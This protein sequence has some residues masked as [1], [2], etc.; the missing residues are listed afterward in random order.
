MDGKKDTD[1][2][3]K[4]NTQKTHR[5]RLVLAQLAADQ[6]LD[7]VRRFKGP[8]PVQDGRHGWPRRRQQAGLVVVVVVVVASAPAAAA[9]LA[10]LARR[11]HGRHGRRR[12][13]RRAQRRTVSG[14]AGGAVLAGLGGAHPAG[15]GD[16]RVA[17][18]STPAAA[19]S[20]PT[21]LKRGRRHQPV[22]QGRQL[23]GVVGRKDGLHV[24]EGEEDVARL[25][26]L[27]EEVP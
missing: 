12:R 16:R 20:T 2:K 10:R 24:D 22:L 1:G 25:A 21:T 11:R 17:A 19:P 7:V 8:G 18:A 26:V 3:K 5:R 27:D 15:R 9:A 23:A 4:K 6:D 13:R 14:R